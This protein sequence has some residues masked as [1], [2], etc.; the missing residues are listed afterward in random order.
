MSIITHLANVSDME[1]KDAMKEL[2]IF[3]ATL[4][5]VSKMV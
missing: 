4:A 3:E 1:A 2:L 5:L